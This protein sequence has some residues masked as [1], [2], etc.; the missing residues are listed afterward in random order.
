MS[1][2][3]I[4]VAAPSGAGKTSIVKYLLQE[5]PQLSFSVSATTR[6]K[7]PNETHGKD[8]YFISVEEF[9]RRREEGAFLEWQEVYQNQFYGS[10]KS[11]V[12]RLS[13]EGKVVIF[14]VDVVGALNIKKYYK[15]EALAVFIKPPTIECLKE[16]LNGRGTETPETLKKRLDK[17]E[18][19]L[20]FENQFDVVV[21]NDKLEQAQQYAH[22]I[23]QDFLCQK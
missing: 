16:R 4:I 2:K 20:S 1:R 19:E 14:D 5:I 7:R 8:Y 21:V 12:D 13:N 3:L 17:A 6:A 22:Q 15:D 11:E 23:I 18:Y 9:Q 10:L